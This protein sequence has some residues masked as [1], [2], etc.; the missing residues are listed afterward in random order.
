MKNVMIIFLL[1]FVVI[2]FADTPAYKICPKCGKVYQLEYNYCPDDG[3][4]LVQIGGMQDKDSEKAGEKATTTPAN[5]GDKSAVTPGD[6]RG[7][8]QIK[9]PSPIPRATSTPYK[10]KMDSGKELQITLSDTSGAA[11]GCSEH[12]DERHGS[13]TVETSL[14]RSMRMAGVQIVRRESEEDVV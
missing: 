8:V 6:S 13:A 4:L 11:T 7:E 12:E 14:A 10:I 9:T 3:T 1:F 2:A 5:E